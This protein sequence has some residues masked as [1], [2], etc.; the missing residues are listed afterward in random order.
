[1][2]STLLSP[3]PELS[4]AIAQFAPSA[5]RGYLAAAS[6]GIP[7]ADTVSAMAHDQELWQSGQRDPMGYEPTVESTR[8][9]FARLIGVPREQVA[10]GSQTSVMASV[11]AL[12]APRGAEILCVEN[13]FTS[14]VFPFLQRSDLR[15]RSVPLRDIAGEIGPQTWL[16]AFS[17][18]Q[19]KT[20]EVAD[21]DAIEDAAQRAGAFTLCDVTQAAGVH[22]V[23][24]T[25]FDATVCHAYKWLCSP[26]GV[27]FMAVGDD[28][29]R[30]LVPVQAGWYAGEQIWGSIYG[31]AM[32]LAPDARRFDVSPA[33]PCWVG[34]EPAIR[35]FADLDI[36]EIWNR[37]SA[38]GDQLCDLLGIA[39]QH[40]AIVTWADADGSEVA[41]LTQAGVRISGRA[42]RARA[43][44]HLWN[45]ESDVQQ[46]AEILGR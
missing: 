18:V 25:R 8:A 35:M 45:D 36:A 9:H 21:V 4:A 32:T 20:G 30:Q 40:Q 3:S 13:D 46:V 11:V 7:T 24:A 2:A 5:A 29:A 27:A 6:M 19:S 26:R 44:F 16:V 28:F 34:A 23:D 39:Q 31:P 42:G 43:A 1:M 15:V 10:I 33:W 12:S 38:L 22:P 17:L 37:C 41:K 14:I